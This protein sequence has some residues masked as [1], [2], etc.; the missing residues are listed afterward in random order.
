MQHF[1]GSAPTIEASVDRLQ[2]LGKR[3]EVAIVRCEAPSQLPHSLD[4]GE[5]RTVGWQEQEAQLLSVLA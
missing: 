1:V 2:H 3:C 4:R 5:L